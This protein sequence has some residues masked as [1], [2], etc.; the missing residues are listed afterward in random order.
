MDQQEFADRTE[1]IKTRLYR[2]AYL[3]L[4]SEADALLRRWTRRCTGRCGG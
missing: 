3:Y 4:G 2:T 1:A